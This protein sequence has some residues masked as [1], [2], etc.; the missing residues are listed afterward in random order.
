MTSVNKDKLKKALDK[1]APASSPASLKIQT[2]IARVVSLKP[3][4]ALKIESIPES[5]EI[6]FT[7]NECNNIA[8]KIV[9]AKKIE[10]WAVS[11]MLIL[12]YKKYGVVDAKSCAWQF[13]SVYLQIILGITL[14]EDK[15]FAKVSYAEET[16]QLNLVN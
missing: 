6:I 4:L 15:H 13:M 3:D 1:L 11:Y 7:V 2:L 5:L 8:D 16:V 10:E 12:F 9:K 14:R